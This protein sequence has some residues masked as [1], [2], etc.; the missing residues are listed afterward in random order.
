MLY[1]RYK[2]KIFY[3]RA[4]IILILLIVGYFIFHK[5]APN[6]YISFVKPDHISR[7]EQPFKP[8]TKEKNQQ[9]EVLLKNSTYQGTTLHNE[10][11]TNY[12]LN[13]EA[14]EK[15]TQN[16]YKGFNLKGYVTSEDNSEMTLGAEK[17]DIDANT[18]TV[19]LQDNVKLKTEKYTIFGKKIDVDLA[20]MSFASQMPIEVESEGAVINAEKAHSSANTKKIYFQ[21]NAHMRLELESK[22]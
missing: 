3:A 4:L 2:T 8:Q 20:T 9:Y 16:H 7:P 12:S 14:L 10:K 13:S 21:G 15:T 1:A 5:L 11:I 18:N 19:A 22:K 17:A 6:I